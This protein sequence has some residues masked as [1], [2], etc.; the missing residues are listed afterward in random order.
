MHQCGAPTAFFPN[1]LHDASAAQPGPALLGHASITPDASAAQSG[2][3]LALNHASIA[4]DAL[5]GAMDTSVSTLS[6]LLHT[7]L[8]IIF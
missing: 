3:G 5:M 8:L 4:P 7:I 2:P 6:L 1:P